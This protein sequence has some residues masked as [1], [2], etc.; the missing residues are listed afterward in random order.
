MNSTFIILNKDIAKTHMQAHTC[1]NTEAYTYE[2]GYVGVGQQFEVRKF[3]F[4][5]L[6]LS[7][8]MVLA[9]CQHDFDNYHNSSNREVVNQIFLRKHYHCKL[10]VFWG[11]QR[12]DGSVKY[13]VLMT[14]HE[15]VIDSDTAG[16][17][18]V[19]NSYGHSFAHRPHWCNSQ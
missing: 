15:C 2:L 18:Y 19:T 3:Y 13:S 1:T 14:L 11:H 10:G 9:V 4:M 6:P 17:Y 16:C 8:E 7:S 5:L 12:W